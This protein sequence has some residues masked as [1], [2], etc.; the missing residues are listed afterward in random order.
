[1]LCLTAEEEIRPSTQDMLDKTDLIRYH[2]Q[3]M[4]DKHH[5]KEPVSDDEQINA[6]VN[7]VAHTLHS[8]L[9]HHLTINRRKVQA[10][11]NLEEEFE[12]QSK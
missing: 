2:V 6:Y 5:P 10:L 8:I 7:H 11:Q 3:N 9:H 1:M 12:V 4:L